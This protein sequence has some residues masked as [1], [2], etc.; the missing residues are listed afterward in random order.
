M[1]QSQVNRVQVLCLCLLT[2]KCYIHRLRNN[3]L[4]HEAIQHLVKRLCSSRLLQWVVKLWPFQIELFRLN[5]TLVLLFSVRIEEPW[6]KAEAAVTLVTSC[7]NLN[8][9]INQIRYISYYELGTLKK[10]AVIKLDHGCMIDGKQIV[11]TCSH[12]AGLVNV[13]NVL[14]FMY[15][16]GWKKLSYHFCWKT[17]KASSV[18]NT[19]IVILWRSNGKRFLIISNASNCFLS[20]LC[21]SLSTGLWLSFISSH[22]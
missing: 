17:I 14:T 16:Q 7:L 8:P 13:N 12:G 4:N 3:C 10:K 5:V 6:I 2:W 19:L 21:L 18:Q 15:F 20:L 11:C 1:I 9:H 22:Y